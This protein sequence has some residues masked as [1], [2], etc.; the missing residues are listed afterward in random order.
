MA[1]PKEPRQK[2]I[3]LMYLVLTALLALNVSSE[4]LN[5]FKT[6]DI[7]LMTANG[8]IE[9]KNNAIFKSFAQ[10]LKDDKTRE[11]AEIWAP[12][13]EQAK[14]F[15]EEVYKYID[16]LK[17]ELK[18][19]AGY[20]PPSDTT[21]KEDNLDVPTRVMLTEGRAKELQKRLQTLKDNLLNIDP[22]IKAQFSTNFPIDLSTIKTNNQATNNDWGAGYFHMTPTIAAITILSKFQN[23][24]RNAE[25]QV[26]DFIHS[27]VGE[28][29][30][31][32][33]EFQAFA[34]TNS[35]YLMP[36]Q[37]LVITA[38][39]GAFS[40][41]ARPNITVDGAGVGLN[42]QGVAEY[43]TNVGGPGS[44][45]KR[46]K[47]SFVKPD[48]T[49]GIVERDVQ[50]TVG[51]PT[52]ASISADAV[53][54]LYIGLD[55]PLTVSGGTKG[56]EAVSVNISQ[57]SLTNQ[58]NGKY[59]ARVSNPGKATINV[60]VDGKTT[61][62]EFR[63]KSVPDPVAMVGN[64]KGG[65]IQANAFKAQAGVR[66]ELENFVFEGVKFTVTGYTIVF[67]GAGFPELAFRQVSGNTF[68]SVRDL[69]EKSRPGTVVTIDEIR[70]SGPGGTRSLPPLPFNLY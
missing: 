11:R 40:K 64:S 28:V 44:Y 32:Y 31:V 58:G 17:M 14:K 35:Q 8:T 47:I 48:G 13:A 23:D 56:A 51:S 22:S 20:N 43:K 36:G 45:T 30:I 21:F 67:Q 46:V 68:N 52:G 42:A 5:A 24:V 70:A 65:R 3:N 12:K 53:K 41:A 66:A 4:I 2:M 60:T 57:G 9:N 10:K 6:V 63:V 54:V 29:E 33:D 37:E 18:R 50:Y 15:S 16:G 1:L 7:S 49:P 27:K 26:I 39:V 25:A 61:P 62:F 38:G 55:N 34:G 59:V 19:A 69:L